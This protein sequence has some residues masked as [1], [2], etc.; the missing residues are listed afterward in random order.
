MIEYD[1]HI[2]VHELI[3]PIG[4]LL[5]Y[6]ATAEVYE[7]R[8]GKRTGVDYD[9]GEVYGRAWKDAYKRMEEQVKSWIRQQTD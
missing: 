4:R 8:D 5:H 2:S 1:Y 3:P 9:L 6:A 7:R